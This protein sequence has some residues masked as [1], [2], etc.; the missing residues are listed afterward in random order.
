MTTTKVVK[1]EA[2]GT[3]KQPE[4][5]ELSIIL[6]F[7]DFLDDVTSRLTKKWERAQ[8]SENSP[9][10]IQSIFYE[11]ER[12]TFTELFV[13]K[14]H[15]KQHELHTQNRAGQ[16]DRTK[17]PD[18]P[19]TRIPQFHTYLLEKFNRLCFKSKEIMIHYIFIRLHQVT[20]FTAEDMHPFLNAKY[21]H[22]GC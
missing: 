19:T 7:L 1:K 11:W 18:H 12:D 9:Q 16:L 3:I 20:F 22:L 8:C 14:K 4:S 17:E 15:T 6:L 10:R 13:S 21:K 2:T 5:E